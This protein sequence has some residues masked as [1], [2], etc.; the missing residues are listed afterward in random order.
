MTNFIKT[1]EKINVTTHGWDGKQYD[2][3]G[4]LREVW[5]L[6]NEPGKKFIRL[7]HRGHKVYCFFII[8]DEISKAGANEISYY[9]SE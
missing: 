2:G 1:K 7:Y 9:W 3:E 6:E 8:T 4:K 5:I